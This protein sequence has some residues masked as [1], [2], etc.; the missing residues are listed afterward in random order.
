MN[1]VDGEKLTAQVVNPALDR[2]KGELLPELDAILQRNIGTLTGAVHGAI[3]SAIAGLGG[4]LY[5]VDG[6][7]A[8]LLAGLDGWT[9][10]IEVPKISIR[11]SGPGAKALPPGV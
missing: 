2:L 8:K 6:D 7:A 5:K 11:L 4:L 10:E 3:D 1:V 9:L